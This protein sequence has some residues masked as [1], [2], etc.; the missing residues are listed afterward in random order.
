ME[1]LT[2]LVEVF[3]FQTFTNV[4]TEFC[5]KQIHVNKAYVLENNLFNMKKIKNNIVS[6]SINRLF[7]D[8]ILADTNV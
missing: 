6:W 3:N 7:D 8:F 1:A 5:I 2:L 4:T